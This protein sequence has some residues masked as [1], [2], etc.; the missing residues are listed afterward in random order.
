VGDSA[1]GSDSTGTSSETLQTTVPTPSYPVGSANLDTFN[2]INTFRQSLGLG[3]WAQNAHL[4]QAAQNHVNYEVA[5]NVLSDVETN[6]LPDFTGAT[7]L[8]RVL[9]TGYNGN[10]VGEVGSSIGGSAAVA[11]LI[12]T[13]YHRSGLM[14]QSAIQVGIANSSDASDPVSVVNYGYLSSMQSNAP[15]FTAY[16][17]LNGQTGVNLFIYPEDII[18]FP[19]LT[20]PSSPISF[21][22]ALGTE[23][24]V[25]SFTVTEAGASAPLPSSYLTDDN[26]PNDTLDSN[27]AYLV[28]NAQFSPNTKYNVTFTGTV[29]GEPVFAQWSFTTGA[30]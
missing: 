5:N 15:G 20:L 1:N 12:N 2:A 24:L 26:D 10:G 29:N 23:L 7:V 11:G 28:G 4:D 27:E 21:I 6:G 17:P 8:N 25:T 30:T 13:V 22:S 3:L 18:A 19:N 14:N 16:Y 9:Y